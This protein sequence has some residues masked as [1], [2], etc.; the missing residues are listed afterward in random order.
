[1]SPAERLLH[2]NRALQKV[3]DEAYIDPSYSGQPHFRIGQSSGLAFEAGREWVPEYDVS[4]LSGPVYQPIQLWFA[5]R[6]K[7]QKKW[8]ALPAER[9]KDVFLLDKEDYAKVAS[10]VDEHF[11]QSFFIHNPQMSLRKFLGLH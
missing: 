7:I 5:H 1:M 10:A 9:K 2:L 11:R 8:S 4:A 3:K 6:D